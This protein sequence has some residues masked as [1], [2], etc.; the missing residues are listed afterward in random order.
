MLDLKYEIP[1][2]ENGVF[3]ICSKDNDKIQLIFIFGPSVNKTQG[4]DNGKAK[5]IRRNIR[6]VCPWNIFSV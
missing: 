2:R 3:I 5:I 6:I 1:K 4:A